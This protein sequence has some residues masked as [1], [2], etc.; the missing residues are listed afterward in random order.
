MRV[1]A[2]SCQRRGRQ[3]RGG[4]RGVGSLARNLALNL[5]L[6]LDL[7]TDLAPNLA[8]V[9]LAL[10]LHEL[11]EHLDLRAQLEQQRVVG[12]NVRPTRRAGLGRRCL[13]GR[14]EDEL[15]GRL[16][17]GEVEPSEL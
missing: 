14:G 13:A 8:L 7:A 10:A 5:D 6:A 1:S 15:L 17:A 11:G 12:L 16:Q 4:S 2:P 9:P 3:R